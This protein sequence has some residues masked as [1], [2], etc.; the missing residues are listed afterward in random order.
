MDS[1]RQIRFIACSYPP[2]FT[3]CKRIVDSLLK[4]FSRVVDTLLKGFACGLHYSFDNPLAVTR[5]LAKL[6]FE[7][8]IDGTTKKLMNCQ[9]HLSKYRSKHSYHQQPVS[10]SW[11]SPFKGLSAKLSIWTSRS[12]SPE[13]QIWHKRKESWKKCTKRSTLVWSS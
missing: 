8:N 13:T 6:K 1:R 7:L 10:I 2:P 12:R 5:L 11:D 3:I 4:R 9:R